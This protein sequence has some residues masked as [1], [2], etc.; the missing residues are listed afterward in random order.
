MT[1]ANEVESFLRNS[2]TGMRFSLPTEK[3][4]ETDYE[5][6]I[7]Y[8]LA[9]GNYTL[10]ISAHG[11]SSKSFDFKVASFS[12]EPE[13]VEE[14]T[15]QVIETVDSVKSEKPESLNSSKDELEDTTYTSTTTNNSQEFKLFL[16]KTLFE[17]SE[18]LIM[19]APSDVNSLTLLT[20]S[21][22]YTRQ[23]LGEA[24]KEFGT[25]RLFVDVKNIPNG[26]YELTAEGSQNNFLLQSK[27]QQIEVRKS[28]SVITESKSASEMDE[29][30]TDST[31]TGERT[32][33]M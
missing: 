3:K 4:S 15:E 8:G 23:L 31:R 30:S 18:M 22:S 21:D 10:Q 32:S 29:S 26:R 7:P 13:R 2:A 5:L 16:S 19:Q 20:K 11:P 6:L 12:V 28:V 14:G 17:E 9:A 27:P 25:W 33:E 24:K 1:H